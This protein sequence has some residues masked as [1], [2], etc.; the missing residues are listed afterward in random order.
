M[1]LRDSNSHVVWDFN[2]GFLAHVANSFYEHG[3]VHET[4]SL[5]TEHTYFIDFNSSS[6]VVGFRNSEAPVAE[7]YGWLRH[8]DLQCV[9]A[10]APPTLLLLASGLLGL[11]SLKKRRS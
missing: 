7:A 6:E 10:P 11:V 1:E 5:S 9:P 3:W 2:K 4:F 8:I